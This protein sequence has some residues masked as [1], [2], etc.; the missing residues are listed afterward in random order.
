M[1]LEKK[2]ET[3]PISLTFP[4]GQICDLLLSLVTEAEFLPTEL[5]QK[6]L[7]LM[8]CND[9]CVYKLEE[10]MISKSRFHLSSKMI[11]IF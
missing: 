3:D 11:V 4:T 8:K 2:I 9:Q 6:S 1:S 7:T 10:Y 5:T